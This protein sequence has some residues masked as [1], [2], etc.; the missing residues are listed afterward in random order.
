MR[1]TLTSQLRVYSMLLTATIASIA[2]LA[3]LFAPE[4]IADWGR[5]QQLSDLI[6]PTKFIAP[7]V[8]SAA[9]AIAILPRRTWNPWNTSAGICDHFLAWDVKQSP[10]SAS[11]HNDHPSATGALNEVW[12]DSQAQADSI[13]LGFF[14]SQSVMLKLAQTRPYLWRTSK[15]TSMRSSRPLHTFSAIYRSRTTSSSS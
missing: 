11:S 1:Y 7:L 4:P 13:S 14:E 15:A 6:E 12:V 3:V 8:L 5:K 2:A 9:L 10:R